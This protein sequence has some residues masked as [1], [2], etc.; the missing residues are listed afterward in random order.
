MA[1]LR[2]MFRFALLCLSVMTVFIACQRSEPTLGAQVAVA[3]NFQPVMDRLQ[4]RFEAET[5]YQIQTIYGSTG[6]LY[7]QILNGAPYDVFLAAD[8]ARP[9]RL[10]AQEF[11]LSGTRFT[12]ASGKLAL[13]SA[14]VRKIDVETL[15]AAQFRRLA[16]A[17]PALAPYG[18]AAQSVLERLGLHEGLKDKLVMG[19]NAGQAFAFVK[20]GNAELGFV[21]LWHVL[22]LPEGARGTYW[23]IDE[24]L[25]T[26]VLQDAQ[27]LL[28]GAE[29][30]AAK[31]F[32]AYLASDEVQA[33]IANDQAF[34]R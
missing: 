12:Y 7:A 14:E 20:T 17:N 21:A 15:K 6:A 16:I 18:A 19:E 24:T 2:D 33:W 30:E 3:T 23:Q 5:G 31:A 22:S 29:N 11:A 9:E 10:E 34:A 4:P 26:P 25:Y 32:L 13:W 1:F 27:L 8:Q 28:Q